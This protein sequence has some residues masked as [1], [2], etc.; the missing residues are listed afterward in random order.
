MFTWS[1]EFTGT[2]YGDSPS[3]LDASYNFKAEVEI[4]QDGAEGI[5]V[6]SGGSVGGYGFY[7]LEG[8]PS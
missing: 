3:I 1:G 4:P 7:V 2:P 6:T 5:I 8:K